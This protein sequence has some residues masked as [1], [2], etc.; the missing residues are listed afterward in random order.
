MEEFV[1][2]KECRDVLRQYAFLIHLFLYFLLFHA[3]Y[4]L[5]SPC[6]FLKLSVFLLMKPEL[7]TTCLRLTKS[8]FHDLALY[9]ISGICQLLEVYDL[10][11]MFCNKVG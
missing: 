8:V 2:V 4:S 7:T 5:L 1:E 3:D 9:E 6:S 11:F 10:V